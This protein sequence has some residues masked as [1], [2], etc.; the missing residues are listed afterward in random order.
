MS[1]RMGLFAGGGFMAMFYSDYYGHIYGVETRDDDF[2][3][4]IN[5]L[6]G[7]QVDLDWDLFVRFQLSYRLM[8]ELRLQD[9]TLD[10]SGVSGVLKLGYHF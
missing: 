5:L 3:P 2:R 9:D 4:G 8:K 1:R 7:V 6:C 10:P